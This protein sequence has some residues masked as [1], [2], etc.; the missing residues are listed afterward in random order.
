MFELTMHAQIINFVTAFVLGFAW[1]FGCDLA[2]RVWNKLFNRP[3][4]TA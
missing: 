4:K 1:T 3:Q 2:K